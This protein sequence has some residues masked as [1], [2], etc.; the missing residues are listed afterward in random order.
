MTDKNRTSIGISSLV[1]ELIKQ[2]FVYDLSNRVVEIYEAATDAKNG[3]PCV[4]TRYNYD[5]V[6]TSRVI[7]MVEEPS[8][9][10]SSWEF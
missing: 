8:S 4:R 3:D 10:D 2:R 7:G 9:W 6:V 5:L 1:K